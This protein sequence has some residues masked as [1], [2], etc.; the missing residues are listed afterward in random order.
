MSS[1][2][3]ISFGVSV[4]AREK[5]LIAVGEQAAL[6]HLVGGGTDARHE[7]RRIEGRLFYFGEI[8]FGIAIQHDSFIV[9]RRFRV[10]PISAAFLRRTGYQTRT[11]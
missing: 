3:G 2:T 9:R 6:Q 7:V 1:V 11:G 8:V 4:K 5:I 10:V